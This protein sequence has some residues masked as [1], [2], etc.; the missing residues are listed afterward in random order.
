MF[1]KIVLFMLLVTVAT[2]AAFAQTELTKQ[3]KQIIAEEVANSVSQIKGLDILLD[4]CKTAVPVL[5]KYEEK[6]GQFEDLKNLQTLI[7]AGKD[8]RDASSPGAK[9]AARNKLLQA[10]LNMLK[11]AGQGMGTI[12]GMLLPMAIQAVSN[13][14]NIMR[15]YNNG[16]AFKDAA[17]DTALWDYSYDHLCLPP[18]TDYLPLGWRL[19]D[20]GAKR[21]NK[22]TWVRIEEVFNALVDL[23]NSDNYRGSTNPIRYSIGDKGP[24][25]QGV[26]F[27]V[28]NSGAS[29]MVVQEGNRGIRDWASALS[30]ERDIKNNPVGGLNDWRLPTKGELEAMNKYKQQLQQA[31]VV[32]DDSTSYWGKNGSSAFAF[33]F[34]SGGGN[35]SP[36]TSEKKIVKVV[37]QF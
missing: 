34:G 2:G 14:I 29:G 31:K 27:M 17:V 15:A 9:D 23:K 24:G 7:Q 37:R 18:Y 22:A 16:F 13:C 33:N 4:A 10:N 6:K 20:N 1:K 25:G 3:E 12:Q 32:F 11:F 35:T 28:S 36:N 19:L 21:N 26:V 30:Y 5:S 8:Y